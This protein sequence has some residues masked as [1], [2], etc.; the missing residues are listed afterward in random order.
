MAPQ[1]DA[2]HCSHV[3]SGPST[4]R[5]TPLSRDNLPHHGDYSRLIHAG[6]RGRAST[7][8]G[9][10]V[11]PSCSKRKCVNATGEASPFASVSVT[12][13]NRAASSAS[14]FR[15]QDTRRSVSSTPRQ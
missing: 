6:C 14:C 2:S 13:M 10:A 5:N 12:T 3:F 15:C 4:G 1:S 11:A 7:D 9:G 8:A